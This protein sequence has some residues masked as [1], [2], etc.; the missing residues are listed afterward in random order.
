MSMA[1]KIR[2]ILIKRGN[3]SEAALA[4]LLNTSPQNFSRKMRRD[5][6]SEDD[7]VEIAKALDCTYEAHFKLNDTGEYI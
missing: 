2:I 7:L 1:E 6:F 3:M 5:N 4:R